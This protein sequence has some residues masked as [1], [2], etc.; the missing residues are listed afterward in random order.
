MLAEAVT[1]GQQSHLRLEVTRRITGASKRKGAN[2]VKQ[3]LNPSGVKTE[4]TQQPEPTTRLNP[5]DPQDRIPGIREIQTT[6]EEIQKC[7]VEEIEKKS[8]PIEPVNVC[9]STPL[10]LSVSKGSS[11]GGAR[12]RKQVIL[13]VPQYKTTAATSS[14]APG[15]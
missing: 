1:L 13:S 2:P 3:V 5:P 4:P 8:G 11:E 15:Y 12:S 9:S 7:S 10:D 6:S 14:L